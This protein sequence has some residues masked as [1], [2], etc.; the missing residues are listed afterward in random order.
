MLH[1]VA[2]RLAIALAG[3]SAAAS[4]DKRIIGG[5]DAQEGDFPFIVS[6]R[7]PGHAC[8]GS[9]LDSTTVLT[10]AHCIPSD[11]Q[12]KNFHVRAGTLDLKKPGVDAKVASA[13]VHPDYKYRG[14]EGEPY[15][16]NDIGIIKLSTPLKESEK[17]GYAKLPAD[18]FDPMVNSTAVVAGWY[19]L[20]SLARGVQD[21]RLNRLGDSVEKLAKVVIPV[22]ERE[23]CY[24]IDETARARDTLPFRHRFLSRDPTACIAL[25]L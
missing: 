18:G 19:V 24:K 21:V 1:K 5:Q 20:F 25:D 16:V 15:A 13:K 23:D 8:G 11:W 22:R 2:I 7:T 9:L 3:I 17:I 14:K 10:A 6:I 12:R 4:I